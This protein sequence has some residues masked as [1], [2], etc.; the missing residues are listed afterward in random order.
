MWGPPLRAPP[1]RGATAAAA[2]VLLLG[3]A[4]VEAIPPLL[5]LAAGTRAVLV[6]NLVIAAAGVLALAPAAL[7]GALPLWAAVLLHEGGTVLVA[8]NS[9]R[10]LGMMGGG[11]GGGGGVGDGLGEAAAAAAVAAVPVP[12][13]TQSAAAGAAAA[14]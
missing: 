13:S 9:L 8:L 2:D 10:P 5:R 11:G 3:G 6:Q 14:A 4:G 1:A 7:A 12:P